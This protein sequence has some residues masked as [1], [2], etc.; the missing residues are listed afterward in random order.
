MCEFVLWLCV[1][2]FD[3]VVGVRA[4]EMGARTHTHTLR[5]DLHRYMYIQMVHAYFLSHTH[6]RG[7]TET[8]RGRQADRRQADINFYLKMLI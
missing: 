4:A 2:P 1:S 8:G 7:Q 5:I 3:R 6:T